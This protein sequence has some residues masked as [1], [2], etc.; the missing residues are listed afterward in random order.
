MRRD[1]IWFED[2]LRLVPR[3]LTSLY[4]AWVRMT[5]PLASIGRGVSIHYTWDFR[6]CLAHRLKVGNAVLIRKDVHFGISHPEALERGEPVIV[7]GDNCAIHRRVQISARNCVHLEQ[8]VILSASVLVMD[9][10]HAFED[11]ARPIR[12]Q[13]ITEG[14]RIR[15]EEGCWIGHGA[16]IVCGKGELVLGRNCVVGANTV[17]TQSFPPYSVIVG[18]PARVVRQY[19]PVKQRWLPEFSKPRLQAVKE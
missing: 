4:T 17:V 15:I 3:V 16:A 11:T 2:P 10:N 7:L 5:Y 14:G 13:G 6:R 18:N 12:E 8:G 9:H 19:D 1:R